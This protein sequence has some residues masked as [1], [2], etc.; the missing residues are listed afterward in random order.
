MVKTI[1]AQ[2]GS[3]QLYQVGR[4]LSSCSVPGSE[5]DSYKR[6]TVA[7]L[8]D[9]PEQ[10]VKKYSFRES[11]VRWQECGERVVLSGVYPPNLLSLQPALCWF[12]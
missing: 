12:E 3:D 11:G 10:L 6:A 4:S 8:A 7:I 2:P 1:K 5:Q 9:K